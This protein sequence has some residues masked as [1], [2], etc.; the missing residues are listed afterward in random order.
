MAACFGAGVGLHFFLDAA[1]PPWLAV[2]GVLPAVVLLALW[3]VWPE[4]RGVLLVASGL[5]AALLAGFCIAPL[6]GPASNKTAVL[7]P[8]TEAAVEGL[9]LGRAPQRAT[10]RAA[11]PGVHYKIAPVTIAGMTPADLPESLSLVHRQPETLLAPG[12]FV[13]FQTDIRSVA[14]S[15][16]P[17]FV[18]IR[19]IEALQHPLRDISWHEQAQIASSN[20]RLDIL[21]RIQKNASGDTAGIAAA[22]IVGERAL[23]SSHAVDALR[24]SGLSHLLAIS[25]LHMSLLAIGLFWVSVRA[26]ALASRQA[27]RRNMSNSAI[28]AGLLTA[29]CY[30]GIAGSGDPA[31]RAALMLLATF[32]IARLA[33]RPALGVGNVAAA[34]LANL[35]L[36]PESL[37]QVGF[38]M[39][40][41][42]TLALVAVYEERIPFGAGPRAPAWKRL[43]YRACI[44]LL[45]LVLT[46]LVA[47]GATGFFAGYHFNRIPLYWL[48]AN[49]LALPVFSFL[50]MP[51]ML[52]SLL[53]MPFGLEAA[54]LHLL[55]VGGNAIVAVG[56]WTG[57][58]PGAVVA[59][60][61]SLPW[62]VPL[63]ALGLCWLCLWQGAWRFA[64][65]AALLPAVALLW[66]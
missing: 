29:V 56:A 41:A 8:L 34:A 12:R 62:T 55:G 15:R 39:S 20:L 64:G 52:A 31:Q 4:R 32:A 2:A 44:F 19:G 26:L 16:P 59:V 7:Q 47:G 53:A 23:I 6:K 28:T 50:V 14:D 36:W 5:G 65:L 63:F 22:L 66:V 9:V 1:P 54:P 49:L 30:L 58:L 57:S 51:M 45:A 11:I 40:F 33:G 3:E 46:N 21:A 35:I 42:A 48:V 10:R 18:P 27:R 13:R 17:V 43:F 24:R 37:L 25:G 60:P 38:Q 61:A